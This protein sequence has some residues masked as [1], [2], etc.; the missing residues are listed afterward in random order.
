MC[1]RTSCFASTFTRLVAD[2]RTPYY[3]LC[4]GFRSSFDRQESKLTKFLLLQVLFKNVLSNHQ[5]LPVGRQTTDQVF[6]V[7]ETRGRRQ[8]RGGG[9]VYR[10]HHLQP[11]VQVGKKGR[12]RGREASSLGGQGLR[13]IQPVW[14]RLW[15]MTVA[16]GLCHP[17]VA[18]SI[19]YAGLD[20]VYLSLSLFLSTDCV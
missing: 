11:A 16:C 2:R 12:Q 17:A 7:W 20:Q 5:C 1:L 18:S 6:H 8:T 3:V 14:R 13:W 15:W 10:Y 4:T 9:E 19:S